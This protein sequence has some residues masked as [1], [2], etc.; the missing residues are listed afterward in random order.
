MRPRSIPLPL[1]TVLTVLLA[2]ES[3]S[4]QGDD[5]YFVNAGQVLRW[6][7]QGSGPSRPSPHQIRFP[8]GAPRIGSIAING[9]SVAF[10]NSGLD[11]DIYKTDGV[12]ATRVYTHSGPV[13]QLAFGS[14][15]DILFF[16]VVETPQAPNPPADGQIYALDLPTGRAELRFT[17]RQST[18]DGAW[19]GTFTV[20]GTRVYVGTFNG[21][22]YELRSAAAP[23]LAYRNAGD[24]VHGLTAEASP[25]LYTTGGAEVYRVRRLQDRSIALRVPG[26]QL[27]H[28]SYA[29]FPSSEGEPCELT[30]QL[31][32]AAPG[33]M[34]LFT[35]V[36]RGPNLHWLSPD[37]APHGGRVATG[38]FRYFVVRGTYWVSMDSKAAD[39]PKTP[40]PG[41]QR[42]ECTGARG[43]AS[44]RF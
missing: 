22:I 43:D 7:S 27:T 17:I 6:P 40:R 13:R 19:R 36:V 14:S 15:D 25:F 35:P 28:V 39:M 4:A 29:P 10:V 2:A 41:E 30:V 18:V 34:N 9:R 38:R 3:V 23:G 42:V 32:G 8:A 11:G 20:N 12:S 24:Q 31:T 33:L 44:F 26:G 37:L 5:I 16:S 1:L 21:G